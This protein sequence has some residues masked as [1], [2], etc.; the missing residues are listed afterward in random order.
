MS[1]RDIAHFEKEK[2]PD[3]FGLEALSSTEGNVT[4]DVI[5]T[6]DSNEEISEPSMTEVPENVTDSDESNT[7]ES[8]TFDSLVN[9]SKPIVEDKNPSMIGNL[10]APKGGNKNK[11]KNKRNKGG[12]HKKR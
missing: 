5:E 2:E 8:V 6:E 10:P 7:I 11:N 4:I 12:N 1:N 3:Y 9:E